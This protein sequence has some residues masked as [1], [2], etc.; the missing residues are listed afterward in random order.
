MCNQELVYPTLFSYV[1]MCLFFLK[2]YFLIIAP[3]RLITIKKNKEPRINELY[4][5]QLAGKTHYNT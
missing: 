4:L 2:F 5:A 1:S 3:N